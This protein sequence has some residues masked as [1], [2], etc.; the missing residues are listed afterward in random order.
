MIRKLKD[1]ARSLKSQVHA[2]YLIARHP[3]TPLVAKAVAAA[4]V[5]YA[6]SP[7]VLIPDFIPV[8][9]LLD[10]LLIIP[11][12]FWLAMRLTP[13]SVKA[14]CLAEARERIERGERLPSNRAAAALIVFIWLAATGGFIW[15]VW[16]A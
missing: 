13:E 2:V 10:D 8:L 6:L 1:W 3:E 7:I 5:V 12:G 15:L 16:P 11:L 4:T 14:Q 9:G